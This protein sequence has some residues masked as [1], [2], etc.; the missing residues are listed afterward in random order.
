MHY[1]G[2][3]DKNEILKQIE[4]FMPS[5]AMEIKKKTD[6]KQFLNEYS[7]PTKIL[8]LHTDIET[9]LHFKALSA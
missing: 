9:P 7:Y 6:L 5:F 2:K 1:T 3:K 8:L 4:T